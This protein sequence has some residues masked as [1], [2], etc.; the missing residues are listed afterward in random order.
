MDKIILPHPSTGAYAN[1]R[2]T[3]QIMMG[4]GAA[5]ALS[6]TL[7]SS[8]SDNILIALVSGVV[9]GATLGILGYDL[10]KVGGNLEHFYKHSFASWT[11]V[12]G[13]VD[14]KTVTKAALKGTILNKP[15]YDMAALA[16]GDFTKVRVYFGEEPK[17]Y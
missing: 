3:G 8:K 9:A 2:L 4:G 13:E 7:S 17:K 10:Y 5:A 11:S 6:T 12:T 1:L 14:P 15:Y 16:T